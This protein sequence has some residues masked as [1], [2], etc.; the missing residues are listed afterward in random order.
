[1][2]DKDTPIIVLLI[3][4]VVFFPCLAYYHKK[5][6]A[7]IL[8]FVAFFSVLLFYLSRGDDRESY[9]RMDV[10]PWNE[11]NLVKKRYANSTVIDCAWSLDK[12]KDDNIFKMSD[13]V[14]CP[15]DNTA[16]F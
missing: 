6:T 12:K 2:T 13:P 8:F 16:P 11:A 5:K 4:S 7:S 3:L 1:M 10:F 9:D 14:V 15:Y